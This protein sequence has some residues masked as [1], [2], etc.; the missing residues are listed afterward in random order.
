MTLSRA[1][2]CEE[3][4]DF[5]NQQ[6]ARAINLLYDFCGHDMSHGHNFHV[7]NWLHEIAYIASICENVQVFDIS[8]WDNHYKLTY[9]LSESQLLRNN[10][11]PNGI[12]DIV[13][14]FFNDDEFCK[15]LLADYLR[16]EYKMF[17]LIQS[18]TST[19]KIVIDASNKEQFV[20]VCQETQ[21]RVG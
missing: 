17:N 8:K 20:Q 15:N 12:K 3:M 2:A 18:S 9:N 6:W 16:P 13:T 14:D 7:V 21:G 5:N 4:I 10:S 19:D 11:L 1:F